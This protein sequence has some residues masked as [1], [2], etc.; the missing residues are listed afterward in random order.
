MDKI[1]ACSTI[2]RE[3][4]AINPDIESEYLEYGLHRTPKKLNKKVQEAVKES[5]EAGFS[6]IRLGYGLCSNGIAGISSEKAKLIV[7]RMHDCI[8]ILLGSSQSYHNEFCKNPGTIYLSRGWIE[9]GGD[10]LT[11]FENYKERV[12]ADFAQETIEL[13]YKN[14]TRLVFINTWVDGLE[15][16]REY[17]RQAA[18][19]V[20]LEFEIKE[21]NPDL[22][23]MLLAGEENDE[24]AVFEPGRIILRT[25]LV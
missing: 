6:R 13:E 8:S 5:E 4:E 11:Q 23:K 17:A 25:D 12:G 2:R 1:I 16:Y 15:E 20:N 14:Y 24:I 18:D 10:P 22:L 7:P 21:G 9:F 3:I 19:F